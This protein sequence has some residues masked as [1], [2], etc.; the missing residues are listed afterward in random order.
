[1]VWHWAHKGNPPCDPWWESETDWHREWKD[2][3]PKD[4]QEVSHISAITGER[5]IADVKNPFG[6]TIEFQHS[7]ITSTERISREDFYKEMVWVVDGTRLPLDKKFFRSGLYGPIRDN[8][9]CYLV[10]WYG[11][12]KLL[13]NWS[14]SKVKVYFD[15]DEENLWRLFDFNPNKNHAI[16][17]P[18]PKNVFIEDCY[19][20]LKIQISCIPKGADMKKYALPKLKK[21][22]NN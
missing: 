20:G 18:L 8:P 13:Y 6:L 7:S 12:S 11:R 22:E 3:F 9:L 17:S 1:M 14:K 4:W 5:H 2:K 10:D 21:I 16:V 15:F 19:N